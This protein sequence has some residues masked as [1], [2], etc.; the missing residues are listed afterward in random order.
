MDIKQELRRARAVACKYGY[1]VEQ[2]DFSG[3]ISLLICEDKFDPHKNIYLY[4]IDY[5]RKEYGRPMSHK[6]NYNT[7]LVHVD[8]EKCTSFKHPDINISMKTF[9]KGLDSNDLD[10]VNDYFFQ[11]EDL[12]DI[13][14]K[15][16]ISESGVSLKITRLMRRLRRSA[17][18]IIEFNSMVS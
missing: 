4:L 11:G 2:D 16:G 3:F 8:V 10:L 15:L 13:A 7:G 12:K 5:L 6:Y 14:T 17:V 9:L 1:Q 18:N